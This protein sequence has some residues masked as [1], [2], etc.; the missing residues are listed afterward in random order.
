LHAHGIDGRGTT[1][2]IVDSFGSPTIRNDLHAFDQEFGRAAMP[3]IPADPAIL[4][5]PKLTIIQ[6]AGKVPAF[7]IANADMDGWAV[8]TTLDVEWAHVFAPHAN[9]LL[10]ETPTDETEGIQGFP[11][12]VAAENYV[13]NHRLADVISQ[14]FGS[15]EASFPSARTIL[16]LRS[17]FENARRHHVTV[18]AASGDDGVASERADGSCCLPNAANSWPSSDPLVTSVGGTEL[19]LDNAG[20]RTAP[21]V[22]WNDSVGS[23]G[24][25]T[26]AI[27][28]RPAFQARVQRVTGPWR[29]TPDI[30]MSAALNGGVWIYISTFGLNVP[31]HVLAGTSEATPEFSGVVAMAAQLR[32]KRLG[33]INKRLYR[34]SYARDGL[35]D[36]TTGNNSFAGVAGFAATRGYDLASGL[37]TVNTPRFVRSLAQRTD[38][39]FNADLLAFV[40]R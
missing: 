8:E 1:I 6:P 3:G 10:V 34:M 16:G 38:E 36:V 23:S 29:S 9:I 12:I 22:V 19:S 28:P 25:G 35:V 32:G 40:K 5:D 30:S 2:A 33:W 27:F 26:S 13:I 4:H 24:G 17:A 21:D 11:E 37:G 20:N 39:Q 15:T 14:S 31:F 18:L 7:N